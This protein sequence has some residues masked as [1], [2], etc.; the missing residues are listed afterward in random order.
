M[1][2]S[3]T[4]I[5]GPFK[6]SP[7]SH[8]DDT[9]QASTLSHSR[10]WPV[11]KHCQR[12]LRCRAHSCSGGILTPFPF[13]ILQLGYDLGSANPQLII[14]AEEPWPFRRLSFLP[15]FAV[16]IGKILIFTGST[17]PYEQDSI[18]AKHLPTT[19]FDVLGLG[20][21]FS[22]VHFRGS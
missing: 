15:S 11:P 19:S 1:G 6:P 8:R 14:I 9:P 16:T 21:L 18:P 10:G 5:Q 13:A 7:G 17:R 20:N 22:P 3:Q 12:S 2:I 4:P